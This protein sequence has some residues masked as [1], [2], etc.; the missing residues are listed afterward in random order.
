MSAS[1]VPER[2]AEVLF[3]QPG[4]IILHFSSSNKQNE[5]RLFPNQDPVN[6]FR[7]TS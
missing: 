7:A 2:L 3:T 4:V 1:I 5:R 6:S